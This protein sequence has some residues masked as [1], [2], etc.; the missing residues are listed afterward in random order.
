MA[1]SAFP[2]VIRHLVTHS[3]SLR[4]AGGC[5]SSAPSRLDSL[6]GVT[7]MTVWSQV[8]GEITSPMREKRKTV[9]IDVMGLKIAWS[10]TVCLLLLCLAS[11]FSWLL[12][13][14]FLM[15]YVWTQAGPSI[16]GT[17]SMHS[18]L[19]C[20]CAEIYFF[21]PSPSPPQRKKIPLKQKVKPAKRNL[22]TNRHELTW[23][24][25]CWQWHIF[26]GCCQLRSGS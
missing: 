9:I 25:K 6:A 10:W 1:G 12:F 23:Q 19:S 20:H 4:K 15:L 8:H 13:F 26:S 3:A 14:F 24:S 22:Y 11:G 5:C 18:F 21:V 2:T 17:S 16:S 7:A